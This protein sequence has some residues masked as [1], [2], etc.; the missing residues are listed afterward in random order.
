MKFGVKIVPAPTAG[1]L[2]AILVL[3]MSGLAQK[4][5]ASTLWTG[6]N[7]NF[8]QSGSNFVDVLVPGAVS[9]CRNVTQWLFNPAG[10]DQGPAAGTPT[11]TEWAFG[12]LA[13]YASLGYQSFDSL[14]NGDLSTLLPGNP[15][16][17]HLI[18]EDIYLSL[19]FSVWPQHGGFFAYT[20][21]TPNSIAPAP[22]VTIT[23]PV[24]G[25]VLAAPANVRIGATATVASG[26]VTNVAFFSGVMPLGAVQSA[27]FSVTAANFA[28][29]TYRLTAVATAGGI[30][31]TSAA[32]NISIVTPKTIILSSATVTNTQFAFNYTADPGLGY[33]IQDSSNLVV[34]QSLVT[35][36]PA[37]NTVHVT[38]SVTSK[39]HLFYRIGRLPNP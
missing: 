1:W 23:N 19:T 39:G 38:E 17:V 6:A 18:N 9:L 21:S 13:N 20:R 34:W 33:V 4:T 32:I 29:G 37:S 10:G 12:T 2:I 5:S 26:S 22:S 27:P 16:V 8:T 11:D 14:R 15:M 25:V 24:N 30:S 31:A 28:A 3:L 7:T 35:N 36:I